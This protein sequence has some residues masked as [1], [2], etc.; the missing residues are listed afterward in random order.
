MKVKA[1]SSSDLQVKVK[2]TKEGATFALDNIYYTTNSAE[3]TDASLPV[4]ESFA[5]WLKENP[6]VKVEIQG[7]TDNVGNPKDNEALSSNRAFSVKSFLEEMGIA[8]ERIEAKGYGSS[9]PLA[10]N[11]TEAGRARNRRTEFMVLSQ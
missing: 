2:E 9:R 8:G 11:A 6:S 4:L 1:D 7:H 3:L 5:K 10:D